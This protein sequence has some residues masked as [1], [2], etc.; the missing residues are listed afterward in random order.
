MR[1]PSLPHAERY[2]NELYKTFRMSEHRH[3]EDEV[4]YIASGTCQIQCFD[5]KA[6]V[7]QNTIVEEGNYF[8]IR[9][10]VLH[11][12]SV[13]RDSPC[14]I[15]NLEYIASDE[16]WRKRTP[17]AVIRDDG[18]LLRILGI[19]HD[20]LR[21]REKGYYQNWEDMEEDIRLS[22]LLLERKIGQQLDN[23]PVNHYQ[24]GKYISA[25][26][27]YIH[28]HYAEKLY[29]SDIAHHVGVAPAYLQRLFRQKTGMSIS[30]YINDLRLK[31]SKFLLTHSE[32]TLED[33]AENAGFRSRQRLAQVFRKAE[34]CSPGEYRAASHSFSEE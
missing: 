19:I 13:D 18:S 23:P 6:G 7:W 28:D 32:L 5:D 34:H 20:K 12:L 8:F 9:G 22:V 21:E 31:R 24:T 1:S 33:V 17:W 15:L 25:A 11:N 29:I 30:E 14:R 26:Q 3:P 16:D 27:E 2:Y 10:G 4:M